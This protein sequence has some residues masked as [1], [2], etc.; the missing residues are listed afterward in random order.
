MA[1]A[2]KPKEAEMNKRVIVFLSVALML[3]GCMGLAIEVNAQTQRIPFSASIKVKMNVGD[4]E[5]AAAF[6]QV[7]INKRL[8][9]QFVSVRAAVP[10]KQEVL[11]ALLADEPDFVPLTFQGIFF[12][13]DGSQSVF[14]ANQAVTVFAGPGREVNGIF[15]RSKPLGRTGDLIATIFGVLEDLP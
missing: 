9:I 11:F 15:R 6:V 7:P 13:E 3:L 4:F 5:Q 14:V 2:V 1:S 10:V 12:L 8:T